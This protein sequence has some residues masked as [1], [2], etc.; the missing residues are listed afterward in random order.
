MATPDSISRL[1]GDSSGVVPIKYIPS[2]TRLLEPSSPTERKKWEKVDKAFDDWRKSLVA[3]TGDS[4]YGAVAS[5]G[6]GGGGGSPAP[7]VV[8]V[9]GPPGPQGP[10]GSPGSPGASGEVDIVLTHVWIAK[11]TDGKPGLGHEHDPYDGSTALKLDT[12][13]RGF[14]ENTVIHF[15]PGTYETEGHCEQVVNPNRKWTLKNN[16]QILGSGIDSTTLKLV[17]AEETDSHYFI[18]GSFP[19]Q[20]NQTDN[21]VVAD[22]TLDAQ[23]IKQPAAASIMAGCLSVCG[24]NIVVTRVKCIGWGNTAVGLECFV[25]SLG[26]ANPN[27]EGD[28]YGLLVDGLE[29]TEPCSGVSQVDYVSLLSVGGIINQYR[30]QPAG[31]LS[32]SAGYVTVNLGGSYWHWFNVGDYAN[33]KTSNPAGY[34]GSY[35]VTEVVSEHIFKFALAANPGAYVGSAQV[36]CPVN[37]G[38]GEGFVYNCIVRNCKLDAHDLTTQKVETHGISTAGLRGAVIEN[39]TVSDVTFG[40]YQDAYRNGSLIYKNNHFYNVETAIY[41]N[42]GSEVAFLDTVVIEGNLLELEPLVQRVGA[43]DQP[44]VETRSSRTPAGVYLHGERT[45]GPYCYQNAI[46]RNNIIR[47]LNSDRRTNLAGIGILVRS[48]ERL[49]V[50]N[51]VITVQAS[52][53][54]RFCENIVSGS[55]FGNRTESGT[56]IRAVYSPLNVP[57]TIRWPD[58][59][60]DEDRLRK[61]NAMRGF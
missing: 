46:I 11:R 7:V 35:R 38:K 60:T 39:N 5:G 36:F 24:N 52:Y 51:N 53:P 16:W 22:I 1:Q 34:N 31:T 48:A 10:P 43:F 23:L 6:G 57:G 56:L 17:N 45:A 4:Y 27:E 54:I 44:H 19:L 41:F 26:K 59:V 55:C 13:L 33:I 32:W 12:L 30:W 42:Y 50:Y 9:P 58:P 18:I 20:S 2:F 8:Q 15:A 21:V 25:V 49:Q 3:Q 40:T 47:F 37:N 61:M 28:L 14:P 29:I